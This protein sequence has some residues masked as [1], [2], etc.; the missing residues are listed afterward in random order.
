M[1]ERVL[2]VILKAK[3]FSA[4]VRV[5]IESDTRREV[6]LGFIDAIHLGE[7]PGSTGIGL[8]QTGTSSISGAQ[9]LG[10]SL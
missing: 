9:R 7:E 2:V 10:I 1:V 5:L 4:S 8:L 6:T 3:T